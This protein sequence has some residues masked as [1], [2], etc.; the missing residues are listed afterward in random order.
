MTV[1]VSTHTSMVFDSSAAETR[2]GGRLCWKLRWS[3]TGRTARQGNALA[4]TATGGRGG[5]SVPR[6]GAEEPRRSRRC[7]RAAVG[8]PRRDASLTAQV[9]V[10][11][12]QTSL[13]LSR[14][15]PWAESD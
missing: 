14:G 12:D 5:G 4:I 2:S 6:A 3:G 7:G 9:A 8:A 11:L 10:Q 1:L 13:S 15:S